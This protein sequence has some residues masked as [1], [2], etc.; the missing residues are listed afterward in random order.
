MINSMN[1]YKEAVKLYEKNYNIKYEPKQILE[2]NNDNEL[3]L[4][5][6]MILSL[7]MNVLHRL[8]LHFPN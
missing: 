1:L 4:F 6:L 7:W 3:S 5:D 8:C 2:S